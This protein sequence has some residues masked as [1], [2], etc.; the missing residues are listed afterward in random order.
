M[1]VG[2]LTVELAIFD[3]QSLKDKRRVILS[4]RQRMS[5]RFNVSVAEVAY[6][7]SPKRSRLGVAIVSDDSR[8]VHAQ[9]DKVV[10]LVRKMGG[11]TLLDYSRELF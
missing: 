2:V 3:A 6:N 5:Q 11:L 4:L 1:I 7:D 9:F 10:E 8:A